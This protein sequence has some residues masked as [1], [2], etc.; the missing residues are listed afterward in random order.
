MW[1][2]ST[3]VTDGRTDRQTDRQTTCN[4]NTALCTSASRGKKSTQPAADLIW[5]WVVQRL[6]YSVSTGRGKTWRSCWGMVSWCSVN[7]FVYL[8]GVVCEDSS[9]DKYVARRMGLAAGIVRNLHKIW[10]ASNISKS[11]KVLLYQ[12]LVQT[13]IHCVSKKRANFETV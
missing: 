13:I 10:K 9:C 8:G 7:S 6:K 4:L 5:E 11:T 12:T 3:N 2:W 1:S